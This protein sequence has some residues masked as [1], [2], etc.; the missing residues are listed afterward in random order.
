ML[1]PKTSQEDSCLAA[2]WSKLKEEFSHDIL[3]D[4]KVYEDG[5]YGYRPH[6]FGKVE[7][8][9]VD[10]QAIQVIRTRSEQHRCRNAD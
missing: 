1:L 6:I 5:E 3:M 8:G 7:D 2:G 4:R 9:I 10:L